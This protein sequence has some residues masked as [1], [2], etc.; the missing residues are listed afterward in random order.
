MVVAVALAV[1]AWKAGHGALR[2]YAGFS[3]IAGA[4][5]GLAI[6]R[7]RWWSDTEVALYL[8]DWLHAEERIAT[9]VEMR[10]AVEAD[11]PARGVVVSSAAEALGRDEATHARPAL[12]KPVHAMAP[13]AAAALVAVALAPLPAAPP[14]LSPPGT[15]RVRIPQAGGL[16]KAAKLAQLSARDDAQRERLDKIAKDAEKLKQDLLLGMEKREA[17][18]RI[19]K[20]E[21][22]ILAE[23][24]SLGEGEKRAGLESA[25]GR[26]EQTDVTRKSARALGDHD[27]ET[28]DAEMERLANAR[29]K[30]DRELARKALE[31]AARNA[32][33]SGAP[34]VGKALEQEKRLLDRRSRRADLLRGL[35]KGIEGAG[36]DSPEL[37][38]ESEALDHKGSDESA[39]KLAE[40][41]VKAL[42]SMTPAEREKLVRKLRELAKQ[43]GIANGDPQARKDLADDLSTPEGQ[44]ELEKELR[45]LANDDTKS[46]E[47]K[48]QEALDDAEDGAGEE[49]DGIEGQESAE[50]DGQG[51]QGHDG[52]KKHGRVKKAVPIP[53]AG[54][55]TAAR[56]GEGASPGASHGA[57]D[58]NPQGGSASSGHD[59][60]SSGHEGETGR[61]AGDTLKSRA[62]GPMNK[63]NAMPSSITTYSPGKAGG[64]ANTRGTGDL[65]VTGPKEVD[66]V[67]RSPVPEEYRN[68]V[69]QYFQP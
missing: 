41:M 27:L 18:D 16:E 6:A 45:D 40:S 50:Q 26:L 25:V 12:L 33:K 43:G 49:E 30:Q 44:E 63:N 13:L 23:R 51:Q 17:L 37:R 38:A 31:E 9:A 2:T 48:R 66:G 57:A 5:A 39:R 15:T 56:R 19:A 11:D 22:A 52:K 21:D 60:G 4:A 35:E 14:P 65:R 34:D 36:E 32:A 24:L 42:E 7:R 53:M 67:E 20:I 59:T 46:D 55:D 54:G 10:N 58:G 29:E 28:M 8:D 3:A 47:A 69:R 61:V 68:Q 62:T 64:T 1:F